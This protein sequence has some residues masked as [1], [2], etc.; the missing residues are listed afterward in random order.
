VG[1]GMDLETVGDLFVVDVLVDQD[2]WHRL[3]FL[4]LFK[5][6]YVPSFYI[7]HHLADT[8]W[9]SPSLADL[10]DISGEYL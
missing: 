4:H 10:L 9:H 8:I 3:S 7:A 5:L 2:E 1:T 6:Q